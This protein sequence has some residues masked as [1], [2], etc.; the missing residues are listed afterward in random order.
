MSFRAL[1]RVPPPLYFVA[2][3]LAG[4]GLGLVRPLPLGLTRTSDQ[5]LVALPLFLVAAFLGLRA[6]RLFRQQD[7]SNA[8]FTTPTALLTSGPFRLTRNPMYLS[9]LL[10]LTAIG[11][12]LDSWWALAF[13]PVLAFALDRYIIPG[14]EAR[15][16]QAFGERYAAYCDEVRR[17]V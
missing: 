16:R 2:C 4:W 14:E 5:L 15:L 11:A 10:I 8:P 13:V 7:T 1:E 3:L 12:L 9:Q 6:L 17:W